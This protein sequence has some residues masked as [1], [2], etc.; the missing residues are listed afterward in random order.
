[1]VVGMILLA[2][3]HSG[4]R[5]VGERRYLLGTWV[6]IRVVPVAT[7][8]PVRDLEAVFGAV[9]TFQNSADPRRSQ[10]LIARLNRNRTITVPDTPPGVRLLHVLDAALDLAR[11]SGGAFD[12]AILPLNTL[13]GFSALQPP[14]RPPQ[15]TAIRKLLDSVGYRYVQRSGP[16]TIRLQRRAALDLGGIA[17]GAAADMA[18]AMLCSRGY[19]KAVLD[20]GGDIRLLGERVRDGRGGRRWLVAIRHPRRRGQYFCHLRL[21]NCAVVTSGDYERYFTWRGKRYHHILNPAVG[22]PARRVLSVTV[23]GP[24][25]MLCDGYAT[26]LFVLGVERGVRFIGKKRGYEALF[27]R[28]RGQKLEAHQSSGFARYLQGNLQL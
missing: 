23:V 17:K 12:P 19:R 8:D 4:E 9:R 18:A 25:A 7:R 13:W 20:F 2:G 22:R 27:V 5:L 6:A 15:A 28:S 16:R 11:E 1:M 3:C 26:T 24:S 10:S 21:T 14:T